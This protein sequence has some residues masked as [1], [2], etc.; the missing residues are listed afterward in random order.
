[1]LLRI[2]CKNIHV[3][4]VF[5]ANTRFTAWNLDKLTIRKK[6][7]LS[8]TTDN[9]DLV[10]NLAIASETRAAY[11]TKVTLKQ[12]YMSCLWYLINNYLALDFVVLHSSYNNYV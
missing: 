9:Y 7:N 5:Y 10:F 4:V 6:T 11:I 12:T 1:M 3:L 8:N 2:C